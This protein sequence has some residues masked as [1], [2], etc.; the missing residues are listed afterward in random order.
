MCAKGEVHKYPPEEVLG[1]NP[2]V[3]CRMN[4][5]NLHTRLYLTVKL[6]NREL[7][8]TTLINFTNNMKKK[9]SE[10]NTYSLNPFT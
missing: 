2:Y 10:M 5:G 9:A 1:I 8:F 3:P 7:P 6:N 4:F